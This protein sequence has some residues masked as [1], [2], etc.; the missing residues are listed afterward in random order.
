MSVVK[1]R[2]VDS[3]IASSAPE[4]RPTLEELRRIVVSTVPSAEERISYGVPFYKL[5]GEL[6]GFAAYKHH[7]SFGFGADVLD[8]KD[9][10]QLAA[11]GYTLGKKT[12][13]IK[14]DQKVPAAVIRRIVRAQA[15]VNAA[16]TRTK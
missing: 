15:K 7:V 16:R 2:D 12:M 8:D 11:K 10:E 5:H 1:P 3:Y 6:V 14:F 9:R 13:Q 4:A